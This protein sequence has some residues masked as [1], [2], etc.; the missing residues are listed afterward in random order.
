[1]D[2]I[3][4]NT[5]SLKMAKYI[6]PSKLKAQTADQ[7]LEAAMAVVH[8]GSDKNFPL[9]GGNVA[10]PKAAMNYAAKALEWEQKRL[11]VER[12]KE[13]DAKVAEILEEKRKAEEIEYAVFTRKRP[14]PAAPAP[15]PPPPEPEKVVDEWVRVEKKVRKPKKEKV[16]EEEEVNNYDDLAEDQESLWE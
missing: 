7:K 14:Q 11:E 1:M 10:V 13:I 4:Y 16:F 8:E 9:L 2:S 15:A 12:N 3:L 6:P 5:I